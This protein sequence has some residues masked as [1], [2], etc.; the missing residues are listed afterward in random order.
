MSKLVVFFSQTGRTK[1]VAEGIAE[2]LR[3]PIESITCPQGKARIKPLRSHWRDSDL[4]V[5]SSRIQ[6]LDAFQEIILGGPVWAFNIAPP[7]LS[8]VQK[9]SWKG[10]KVILFITEAGMGGRRAL[11]TL[12]EA[13][14]ERG[15]QI[16]A[17][18][19]FVSSFRSLK[20]LRAR[21][22]AWAQEI[23]K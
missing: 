19:I 20:S 11:K 15:A 8:F 16:V 13:L 14:Q 23:R 10:K 18:K 12:R 2:E 5:I 3:V 21:G 4:P 22:K 17:E 9:M 7:L 1:A 6:N